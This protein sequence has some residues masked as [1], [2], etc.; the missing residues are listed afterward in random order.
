MHHTFKCLNSMSFLST[1]CSIDASQFFSWNRLFGCIHKTTGSTWNKTKYRRKSCAVGLFVICKACWRMFAVSS[2]DS[3]Y[4]VVTVGA[5][6]SHSQG[7]KSGG[8]QKLLSK[9]ESEKKRSVSTR[10]H[11]MLTWLLCSGDEEWFS[12]SCIKPWT[13]VHEI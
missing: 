8:L 10:A 11:A 2:T 4:D 7:F 13:P 5:P 1:P 6:A 3:F 9:Y 12:Y